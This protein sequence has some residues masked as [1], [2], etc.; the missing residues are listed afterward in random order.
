MSLE[1]D[2]NDLSVQLEDELSKSSTSNRIRIKAG[3]KYL[4]YFVPGKIKVVKDPTTGKML[5]KRDVPARWKQTYKVPAISKSD[6]DYYGV[7]AWHTFRRECLHCQLITLA[8]QHPNRLTRDQA[9]RMET[10]DQFW[11]RYHLPAIDV[12]HPDLGIQMVEMSK[13]CYSGVLEA[14]KRWLQRTGKHLFS[15]TSGTVTCIDVVQEDPTNNLSIRYQGEG[16]AKGPTTH[17]G[18]FGMGI[19][20]VLAKVGSALDPDSLEAA[21]PDLD[22][23]F[24]VDADSK[25]QQTLGGY[26]GLDAV[27]DGVTKTD[28]GDEAF[29]PGQDFVRDEDEGIVAGAAMNTTEDEIPTATVTQTAKPV[30][31]PQTRPQKPAPVQQTVAAPADED[32]PLFED[33]GGPGKIQG[34]GDEPIGDT[35]PPPAVDSKAAQGPD[36]AARVR[37]QIAAGR[38]GQQP[39]K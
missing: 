15:W 14:N 27:G 20:Q 3:N 30:A 12:L 10:N 11:G 16:G 24:T 26:L 13:S 22:E 17:P 5:Q 18:T 7:C 35:A 34:A 4:L 29:E 23:L 28:G 37:A 38:Q 39:K 6:K 25:V 21:L 36:L 8:K 31:Q 1:Y 19:R 2:V 32:A 9:A 33:E